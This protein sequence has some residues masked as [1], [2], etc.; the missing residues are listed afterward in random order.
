MLMDTW[1]VARLT[2][3]TIVTKIV[4]NVVAIIGGMCSTHE[5][6]GAEFTE[7]SYRL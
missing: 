1:T 3:R 4:D 6:S 2:R 7:T 5:K